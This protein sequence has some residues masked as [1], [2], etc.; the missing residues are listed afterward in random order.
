MVQ[1][2]A[3]VISV[4]GLYLDDIYGSQPVTYVKLATLPTSSDASSLIKAL[5]AGE[6]YWT[7][8]EVL[9]SN[10]RIVGTGARRT[11]V[12]DVEWTFPLEFVEVARGDSKTTGRQIIPTTDLLPNSSKH[13]EIPF[14]ADGK[15][16][17]RF[18]A[19]DNAANGAV[20]QPVRLNQVKKRCSLS[21]RWG[22]PRIQIACSPSSRRCQGSYPVA[23]AL[24]CW[25]MPC[26]PG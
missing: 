17:V 7:T 19:W 1:S 4:A 5:Q 21:P 14:S 2:D 13:F 24:R 11:V 12:A 3:C 8:G 10:Y 25:L 16:W 9:V 20:M 26:G 22:S 23:G 6:S 18:A 15:K